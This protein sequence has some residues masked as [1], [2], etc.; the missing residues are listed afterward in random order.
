MLYWGCPADKETYVQEMNERGEMVNKAKP[1]CSIEETDALSN[2][3]WQTMQRTVLSAGESFFFEEFLFCPELSTIE[4]GC[5]CCDICVP[6]AVLVVA[7]V[8]SE[9]F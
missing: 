5:H 2:H 8:E 9:T 4:N 7:V 1:F 3:P 6:R